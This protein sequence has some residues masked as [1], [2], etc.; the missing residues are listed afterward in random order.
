MSTADERG[1]RRAGMREVAHRAG[2][3]TQTV[4]RVLNGHPHIREETRARVSE[5]IAALD[6][7]VNNAARTLGTARTRT[8]GVIASDPTLYGPAAGIAALESAARAQGRWISTAYARAEDAA[9]VAAAL[10]H[11]HAQGVDGIILVGA[12]GRT[13]EVLADATGGLPFATLHGGPGARR[14][15]DGA[16]A[17]VAHLHDLGHRRIARLGGPPDWLDESARADGH[18]AALAA[19][20]LDPGPVWSGDWSARTGSDLAPAVAE[21]VRAPG[22]PTAIVVANDQMAL[23]LIAG[24]TA[25]G[26]RVPDEVSVVGFDDNPDAAF[27]RP[28]LTTV[29]LDVDGE[30][31]AC[32]AAVLRDREAPTDQERPDDEAA[33]PGEARLVVRASSAPPA[34]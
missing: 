16:A 9:S 15:A 20:G 34:R 7:R 21:A 26:V 27:Y 14:Q 8:L 33:N 17:V 3:S 18:A 24:L 2:V 30:A 1:T 25:A 19:L 11:V 31:R 22:G 6:Y 13:L 5:A 10:A 28:A 32:I 4:S 12:H 23:G 29:R